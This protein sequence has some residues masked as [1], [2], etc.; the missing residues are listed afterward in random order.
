MLLHV[1]NHGSYHRGAVG[2][3]LFQNGL[4]AP[5]DV[6]SARTDQDFSTAGD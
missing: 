5:R 1:V 2:E 4:S 3:L 6:L